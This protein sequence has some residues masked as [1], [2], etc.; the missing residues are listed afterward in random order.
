MNF[1]SRKQDDCN[2]HMKQSQ[3]LKDRMEDLEQCLLQMSTYMATD[4]LLSLCNSES[5][6]HL[7]LLHNNKKLKKILL[8][9]KPWCW[10]ILCQPEEKTGDRFVSDERKWNKKER[11]SEG[12]KKSNQRAKEEIKMSS[13]SKEI[14]RMLQQVMR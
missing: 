2:V 10:E 9:Y 12:K 5:T 4:L 1:T 7:R 13:R 14:M 8:H 3:Q 11:K 6:Q